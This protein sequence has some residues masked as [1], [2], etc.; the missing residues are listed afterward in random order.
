MPRNLWRTRSFASR[1]IASAARRVVEQRA[2]RGAVGGEVERIV[3]QQ[4]VSPSTI[5]S[6]M[7]PIATGDDRAR[8]PH[9]LGDGQP[10][11]L[12]QALLHDHVGATLQRVDDRGVLLDVGHRQRDEVHALGD[13]VGHASPRG[14]RLRRAPGRPPGRRSRPRRPARRRRG[15]RRHAR[16]RRAARS[17]R[18]T[19]IG[20]LSASQRETWHARAVAT[21]GG[22]RSP[23]LRGAVDAARA[24]VQ[25]RE[26]RPR[27]P[28]R[29]R[30]S[31]ATVRIDSTRSRSSSWFLGEKASIDGGMIGT[32]LVEPAPT[33]RPRAR[34]RR[35]PRRARRG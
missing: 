29:P 22:R 34:R 28:R 35:R 16:A 18:I 9:R 21:S 33:R 15:A 27:R 17:R 30:M 24:P 1:P 14:D 20:S 26:G 32:A 13:V 3:E 8:L 19:P 31:P 5:W 25:A 7:P 10:E 11:A 6:W 12:G 2:D 23:A 4:P